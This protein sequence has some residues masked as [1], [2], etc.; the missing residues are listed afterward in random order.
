MENI[1]YIWQTIYKMSKEIRIKGVGDNT[2]QEL[3]NIAKWECSTIT[4]L[5]K[6]KIRELINSYPE[7]VRNPK[8]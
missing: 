6:P 7:H 1:F 5:I 8:K 2:M 4:S 3:K